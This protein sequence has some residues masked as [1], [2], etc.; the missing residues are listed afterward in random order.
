MG[1]T[2]ITQSAEGAEEKNCMVLLKVLLN[3]E[4]KFTI[5]LFLIS[6]L[7]YHPFIFLIN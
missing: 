5:D 4:I 6:Y 3:A 7:C 2:I 1:F